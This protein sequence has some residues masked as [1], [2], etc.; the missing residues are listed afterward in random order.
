MKAVSSVLN[1][2][3]SPEKAVLPCD[4]NLQLEMSRSDRVRIT[5]FFDME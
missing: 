2:S 3:K 1:F 4:S 5:S